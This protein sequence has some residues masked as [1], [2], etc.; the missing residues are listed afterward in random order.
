MKTKIFYTIAIVLLISACS[1]D[2]GD[3]INIGNS[4]KGGSMAR[5]TIANNHLYVVDNT[6]LTA[7]NIST[8][9][10]PTISS[11]EEVGFGIETVFSRGNN[12]FLGAQNGM[13]IYDISTPTNPTQISYYTH[14]TSCDPVVVEGDL[15]YVTLRTGGSCQTGFTE[16]QLDIID[17]SNLENPTTLT[18]HSL[19][20]PYGL[21]VE[22]S[23]LFVCQGDSGMVIYD[24]HDI[25][26]LQEIEKYSI[27]AY[28]VIT[29]NGV[30]IVIGDDGLHQYNYTDLNNITLLSEILV[31]E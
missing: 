25:Y 4:G 18:T 1:K 26:N 27:K 31:G 22:D 5:F 16:D 17:I 6:N 15:A 21:A 24:A 28:D 9:A 10:N 14:I 11:T 19:T 7:I 3:K 29:N 20:T 8:P 23:T 30:L 12:L 2:G 13:Y